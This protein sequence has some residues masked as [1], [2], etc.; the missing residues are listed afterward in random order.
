MPEVRGSRGTAP[1][2]IPPSFISRLRSLPRSSRPL[3][4]SRR[5]LSSVFFFASSRP[6]PCLLAFTSVRARRELPA[7]RKIPLS[8]PPSYLL[9]RRLH[10]HPVG[11][12]SRI[13][14]RALDNTQRASFGLSLT[15]STDEIFHDCIHFY[16]PSLFIYEQ[17]VRGAKLNEAR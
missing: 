3:S 17:R 4:L 6:S 14:L 12:D 9:L 7:R 16:V 8:S 11:R 10:S 1:E 15:K 13:N 2:T 5:P